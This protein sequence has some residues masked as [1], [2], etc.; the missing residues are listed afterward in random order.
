M[1]RRWK[2]RTLPVATV[3]PQTAAIAAISEAS[4]GVM[5][6]VRW[7]S[8]R[9]AP[10]LS[11]VQVERQDPERGEH[12]VLEVLVLLAAPGAVRQGRD[13]AR[14]LADDDCAGKHRGHWSVLEPAANSW[15]AL[16]D[17]RPS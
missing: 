17:D 10:K 2:S 15:M 9:V 5:V 6:P 1:P 16:A 7:P 14:Q 12:D 8:P 3:S 11:D 13:A 4:L